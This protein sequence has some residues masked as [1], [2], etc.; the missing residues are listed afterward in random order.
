MKNRSRNSRRLFLK[1]S[2]IAGL[3]LGI[4]GNSFGFSSDQINKS[5][6]KKVG[7]IGL[8]TSHS[9]AF[10]KVLN[11]HKDDQMYLGYH[12]VAAYPF[13]SKD[14][15]SS[16]DRIPG[17][18]EEIQKMGLEI[19]GSIAD[20]LQIV[21][22]VLLETNDGK[23]H[24][25][26]AL[27]VFK[28]GK[29]MFIDK[30]MTA[31]LKDAKAIF[32]ASQKYKIPVFSASSLRYITGIDKI[33]KSTV[34]GASTFSPAELEP[35]HPDLFWYGIHGV[36]TL[37]TVMGTGCAS[38]V[39]V[40]TNDTD[41]VTGIWEDGRVGTFRGTR[42]GKHDYGGTVFTQ[43]GNVVLGPYAGYEP[44]LLDIVKYFET[45]IV[46]VQPE[47]TLEILAFMEAADI[48]KKL[49]GKPVS[50]RELLDKK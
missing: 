48:S 34:I 40:S 28:A 31:S 29:R 9:I 42:T 6:G 35:S 24:L 20:L 37:F 15:Q 18:T 36:E 49:G 43:N 12:V 33:D 45:G 41:V 25:E 7:I 17:Y 26:Q 22:V 14:I 2:T 4:Y 32:E 21:G 11:G 47:E 38:V 19:V 5:Q 46:P 39:R 13:G 50:V 10:T 16:I 3:G 1:T 27:E 23:L 44:L 8:D 30:P